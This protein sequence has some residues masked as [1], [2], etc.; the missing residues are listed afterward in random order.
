MALLHTAVIP[1]GFKAEEVKKEK[2][3]GQGKK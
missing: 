2:K 3:K 1:K